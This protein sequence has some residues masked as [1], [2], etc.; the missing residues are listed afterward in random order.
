MIADC[1]L[2]TTFGLIKP[3]QEI[4]EEKPNEV[5]DNDEGAAENA[6]PVE[7]PKPTKRRKKAN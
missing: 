3:G 2:I 4:P 1:Y 6:A 7:A 5:K